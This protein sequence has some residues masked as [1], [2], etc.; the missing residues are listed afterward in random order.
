M[1][2]SENEAIERFANVLTEAGFETTVRRKM[3]RTIKAA[4]GQLGAKAE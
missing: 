3:G 2:P 4:C 1:Q